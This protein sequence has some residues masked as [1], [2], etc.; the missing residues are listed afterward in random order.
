MKS[1]LSLA[2]VL[3]AVSALSGGEPAGK[4]AKKTI[5]TDDGLSIVC[6]VG[7]QGD[8]ALVFLHGW[9]GER[10][11][12]KQ[13]LPVFAADFRVVAFDQAGHGESGKDRKVWSVGALAG[14]VEAVVKALGLKRVV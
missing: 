6:D 4:V 9:C 1:R 2:C 11:Y 12:W 7:G 10:A 5:R 8:T 13:Q 14:D 3:L